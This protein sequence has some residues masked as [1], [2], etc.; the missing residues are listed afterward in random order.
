MQEQR[1]VLVTLPASYERTAVGYPV[2]FM[3]DGSSHILHATATSRR[4]GFYVLTA[5]SGSIPAAQT[6]SVQVEAVNVTVRP[7][8]VYI[9][10]SESGPHLNFDFLLETRTEQELLL[11]SVELSAFDAGGQLRRRDFIDR[12]SRVSL[13]LSRRAASQT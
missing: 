2:L 10:R 8:P 1:R 12:F 11:T 5:C 9:E 6:D 13:I 4:D 3:L 7:D